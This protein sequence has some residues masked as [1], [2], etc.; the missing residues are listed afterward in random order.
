MR[1]RLL[2]KRWDPNSFS[3]LQHPQRLRQHQHLKNAGCALL[4]LTFTEDKIRGDVE[5]LEP[6]FRQQELHRLLVVAGDEGDGLLCLALVGPPGGGHQGREP[7]RA[8]RVLPGWPGDTDRSGPG[9]R[10]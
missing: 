1:G 5:G 3:T 6:Y 9:P 8:G 7:V 4:L 2:W 10:H